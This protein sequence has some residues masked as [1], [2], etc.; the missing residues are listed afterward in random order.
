M[1]AGVAPLVEWYNKYGD[2]GLVSPDD[3][4]VQEL[5]VALEAVQP[6]QETFVAEWKVLGSHSEGREFWSDELKAV[7][8]RI[9]AFNMMIDGFKKDNLDEYNAGLQ[10]WRK[11][12]EFGTRAESAM[13]LIRDRCVKQ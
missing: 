13:L 7:E 4:V 1:I 2:D 9:E 3:T 10:R 5:V 8:L 12:A 6:Y 11:A